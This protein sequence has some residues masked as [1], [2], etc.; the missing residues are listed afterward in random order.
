MYS[1]R[2]SIALLRPR[3]CESY[4][5][6][7]ACVYTRWNLSLSTFAQTHARNSRNFVRKESSISRAASLSSESERRGEYFGEAL[8]YVYACVSR[9]SIGEVVERRTSRS[10]RRETC[11]NFVAATSRKFYKSRVSFY[12]ID[13]CVYIQFNM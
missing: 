9:R 2:S 8:N 1:Q 6:I 4:P 3:E 10:N 13:P 7:K 5:R 12:W 11:T